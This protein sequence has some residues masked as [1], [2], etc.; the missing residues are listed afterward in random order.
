MFRKCTAA[1]LTALLLFSLCACTQQ[2]EYFEKSGFAMGSAVTV[3]IY[4]SQNA[5]QTADNVIA[6]VNET[7]RLLSANL[8]DS[9]IYRLNESKTGLAVSEETFDILG[10]C[11]TVCNTT[12]KV[13]DI[14]IGAVSELWGFDTETPTLPAETDLAA[15]LQSVDMQSLLLDEEMLTVAKAQGQ[16]IDLGAF[17]KGIACMRAM[18]ALRTELAPAIISVGGTILLYGNHPDA[19]HWSIGIRAPY[20]TVNDYCATLSLT[21]AE[22][23][24]TLVVST[25]GSYE[26]TFTENETTYHH[27]LNPENG[28]PVENDLLAVTVV[29]EGGLVSDALSTVLFIHGLSEQTLQIIENYKVGVVML[30]KDGRMLVS[31]SLAGKITLTGSEWTLGD[32]EETVEAM[33]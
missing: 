25:S 14:T 24:D 22:S 32:L 4:G 30:L 33:Q 12:G 27:I 1:I 26:K 7:D 15:A 8:P 17:G 28:M 23:D 3:R 5:Q 29:A 16:K 11:L 21:L 10:D 20:K 31:D 13:L 18:E 19:D 9:D 2:T 6:A